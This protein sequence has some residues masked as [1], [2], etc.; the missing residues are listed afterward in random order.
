MNIGQILGRFAM[1]LDLWNIY[2]LIMVRSF[3]IKLLITNYCFLSTTSLLRFWRIDK[4]EKSF[5]HPSNLKILELITG[6]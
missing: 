2:R 3:E 1:E 4:M 6:I 5:V